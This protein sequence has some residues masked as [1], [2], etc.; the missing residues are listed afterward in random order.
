METAR[1]SWEDAKRSV[2]NLTLKAP[3]DGQVVHNHLQVGAHS[4]SYKS[5]PPIRVV[6]DQKLKSTFSIPVL[7]I[8]SIVAGMN[9]A[10]HTR[11]VSGSAVV[12]R[13]SPVV[14]QDTGTVLVYF[15]VENQSH[16]FMSGERISLEIPLGEASERLILPENSVIFEGNKPYVYIARIPT[17]DEIK[18]D[19]ESL[20]DNPD[21]KDKDNSKKNKKKKNDKD[22]K[23]LT[24]EQIKKK[25]KM[26]T[27]IFFR[28]W[29]KTNDFRHHKIIKKN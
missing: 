21:K 7:H 25:S 24:A 4:S 20:L 14:D 18:S 1:I 12:S 22:D 9:L 15:D 16:I 13:I 8:G 5:K 11:G 6:A 19:M 23:D 27:P 10:V 28:V 29:F 2:E 26:E 17:K 3:F